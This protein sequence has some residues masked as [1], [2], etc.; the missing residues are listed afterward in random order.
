MKE[1]VVT[2]REANLDDIKTISDLAEE[3]WWPTYSPILDKE[4]IRY[5]LDTIY[6]EATLRRVISG[7]EQKFLL[8]SENGSPHGFASFG[9]RDDS[10]EV[11]KLHKIYVLPQDQGKG[12]GKKLIEEVLRLIRKNDMHI[13][14]LNVNRFNP[15]KSF[16]EK[17]G[18]RVIREEDIPIGPYWMNDY[19]MRI[20]F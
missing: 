16:Y 5:M 1:N 8:L 15:A 7:G 3:T 20:E 2:I 12:Y 6:S 17:M 19:V 10:Q 18:F 4:Q 13:L 9:V 14:D 11:Y